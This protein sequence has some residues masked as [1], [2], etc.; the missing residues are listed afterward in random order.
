VIPKR[1]IEQLL[2]E[3]FAE[4]PGP[5]PAE[6]HRAV[7]SRLVTTRQRG[8]RTAW[9]LRRGDWLR[10]LAWVAAVASLAAVAMTASGQL[11]GGPTPSSAPAGGGPPLSSPA[12]LESL[13]TSTA[14]PSWAVFHSSRYGYSL[15]YPVGFLV[16]E[17]PGSPI[18][19]SIM[20]AAGV[21]E[22]NDPGVAQVDITRL[23][24]AASS[25]LDTWRTGA[26]PR[27]AACPNP[28]RRMSVLIAGE[29]AL[30]DVNHCGSRYVLVGY[31]I[32]VAHGYE[33]YW[34]SPTGNEAADLGTFLQIVGSIQFVP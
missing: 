13:S 19:G 11:R 4:G 30:V 3:F 10:R 18:T 7:L 25:N 2:D 23:A 22:L 33:V 24:V 27:D 1:D 5:L 8:G 6:A 15:R 16:S 31:V 12:P 20:N 9:L 29:P 21:D 34:S 28:E 32:H 14:P 26:A 17:V